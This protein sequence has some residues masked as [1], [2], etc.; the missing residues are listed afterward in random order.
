MNAIAAR[1]AISQPAISRHLR[2]LEEAGLV[3]TGRD[4]QQRPRRL[5]PHG[6][7]LAQRFLRDMASY[8][9]KQLDSL[10]TYLD[11]NQDRP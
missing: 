5:N 2:V 6:L 9:P 4:A 8:W 3:E 1:F 7:V 10:A 11:Q